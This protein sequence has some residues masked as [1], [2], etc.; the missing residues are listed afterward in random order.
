MIQ[1]AFING[2]TNISLFF[3]AI[4]YLISKL[5]RCVTKYKNM[6][7]RSKIDTSNLLFI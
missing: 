6:C 2:I 7:T 4:F 3:N 5:Y 1:S